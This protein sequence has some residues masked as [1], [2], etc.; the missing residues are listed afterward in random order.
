MFYNSNYLMHYG[1]TGQK[2]GVRRFQNPNGTLTPE[3]R[4]RYYDS[5]T[6]TKTT[7]KEVVNAY[8]RYDRARHNSKATADRKLRTKA[9][10]YYRAE[11]NQNANAKKLLNREIDK[12]E[13]ISD[14][15][16]ALEKAFREKGMS[17]QD[18]Q[19]AALK[20]ERVENV[21]K[22]AGGIAL[23]VA[24]AYGARKAIPYINRFREYRV[25]KGAVV[26]NL[27]LDAQ[28]GLDNPFYAV[29]KN[30]DKKHY[31]GFFG[32]QHLGGNRGE[33][34]Y[35]MTAEVGP[36]GLKVASERSGKK[37]LQELMEKDK[38]FRLA[39]EDTINKEWR[40]YFPQ[41]QTELVPD[42]AYVSK[43]ISDGSSPEWATTLAKARDHMVPVKR[44]Y[45]FGQFK[46]GKVNRDFYDAVNTMLTA[47]GKS[48]Q[49]MNDKFYAQ[50]KKMGYDAIVDVNDKFNV[51]R[52]RG[53][54][55]I[56]IFN[57]ANLKNKAN[58]LLSSETTKA[59]T[60]YAYKR[61]RNVDISRA[62]SSAVSGY[63]TGLGGASLAG[64]GVVG[65]SVAGTNA[66][67]AQTYRKV[68]AQYRSEHPNSKLS[69]NE[70]LK[71]ELGTTKK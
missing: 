25:H 61:V 12:G 43:M 32:G 18:A 52:Y 28:K 51:E 57:A 34:V 60:Q 27:S 21:L 14:R 71:N 67:R 38:D 44:D 50:L 40:H 30:R 59:M 70:I 42:K 63:I 7:R 49:I 2:W 37:A 26:Q 10:W 8:N 62:T 39:V 23:G 13:K 48:N 69:D 3:G 64:L 36:K 4:E 55:P 29:Y 54:N 47:H 11:M 20:R 56:I 58:E 15:R 6:D 66:D 53:T 19:V 31:V 24:L 35:K 5:E 41:Y 45:L 17:Q 22:V 33:E 9:E 16:L 46:N 68:I 65:L 1:I